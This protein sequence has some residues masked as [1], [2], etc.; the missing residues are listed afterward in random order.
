MHSNVTI[1]NVSW[2][3]FSWATLYIILALNVRFQNCMVHR[4]T[5]F[6][7]MGF[8]HSC[9]EIE[10]LTL[11]WISCCNITRVPKM[12]G[13]AIS[14]TQ[15]ALHADRIAAFSNWHHI[16]RLAIMSPAFVVM[17]LRLFYAG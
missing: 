5:V 6:T 7:P 3:H 9:N 12:S 10:L 13:Y 14:Q 15:A 2:P 4:C 11:I 1:K 8:A 16:L 17:I